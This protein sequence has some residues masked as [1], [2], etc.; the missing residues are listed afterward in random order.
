[1]QMDWLGVGRLSERSIVGLT[2]TWFSDLMVSHSTNTS[3]GEMFY[4][5][6]FRRKTRKNFY[7]K[8]FYR[9]RLYRKKFCLTFYRKEFYCET[10]CYV[11]WRAYWFL[12]IGWG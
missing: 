9:K 5:I 3:Y 2:Y 7:R 6:E 10:S 11:L 4:R 8:I 1:M 12:F